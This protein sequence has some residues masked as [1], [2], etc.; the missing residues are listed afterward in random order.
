MLR[1][2]SAGAD[3]ADSDFAAAWTTVSAAIEELLASGELA[4]HPSFFECITALAWVHFRKSTCDV[5]VLEVGM[6]GR[7]DATNISRPLV[8]VITPVDFHHEAYL[9]NTLTKIAAEKA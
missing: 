2:E 4:K 8:S 7:L 1:G 6:G 3:I 5:Q 9:G